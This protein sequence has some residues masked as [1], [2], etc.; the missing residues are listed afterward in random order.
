MHSTLQELQPD[1]TMRE[2]AD[3]PKAAEDLAWHTNGDSR[4]VS[5][6]TGSNSGPNKLFLAS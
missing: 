4:M 3:S 6:E 2:L 1:T 5:M